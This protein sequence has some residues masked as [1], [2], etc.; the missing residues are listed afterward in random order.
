MTIGVGMQRTASPRTSWLALSASCAI[1][2]MLAPGATVFAQASRPNGASNPAASSESTLPAQ[3]GLI[4]MAHV[5]KNSYKF[6]SLTEALQKEIE[7]A[8][9]E[10]KGLVQKIQ[11]L[12]GQLNSGNLKPESPDYDKLVEQI[13]KSKA[14]LETFKRVSQQKFL[15]KEADIYKSVYLDVEDAV[16]RYATYYKYTLVLRFDRNALENDDNPREVMNGLNRQVIHYRTQDDMTDPVLKFLNKE[17]EK[18]GGAV[19]ES[20]APKGK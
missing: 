18:N 13:A 20:L 16:R 19:P 11:E 8:D 14:E 3:V 17:W 7:A 1:L 15:R 2:S 10:A 4:D 9:G 6:L 12:Q 5:F